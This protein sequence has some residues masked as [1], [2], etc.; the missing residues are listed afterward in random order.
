MHITLASRCTVSRFGTA[1]YFY[2]N[3]LLILI[4]RFKLE[5][6]RIRN[7]IIN[8][9]DKPNF[10]AKAN[11]TLIFLQSKSVTSGLANSVLV[12][13]M[14]FG[15]PTVFYREGTC[16]SKYKQLSAALA[17]D[18]TSVFCSQHFCCVFHVSTHV[19]FKF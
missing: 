15:R 19:C 9:L 17:A 16:G 13:R 11:Q 3:L 6:M 12:P 1:R 4:H 14:N 8:T 5:C 10:G 2:W 7:V 18:K